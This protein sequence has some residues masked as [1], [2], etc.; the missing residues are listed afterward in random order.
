MPDPKHRRA[1]RAL[2]DRNARI[3]LVL[4]AGRR[5]G[6]SRLGQVAN[7]N[8]G[9]GGGQGAQHT[10][11]TQHR[12][13]ADP[14]EALQGAVRPFRRVGAPPRPGE[15]G[16]RDAGQPRALNGGDQFDGRLTDEAHGSK[17]VPLKQAHGDAF[18]HAVHLGPGAG[19]PCV[20]VFVQDHQ[21]VR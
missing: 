15:K 18:G 17:P 13:D 14:A 19:P 12:V 2:Q 8:G 6:A 4:K 16:H 7:G 11:M 21:V 20:G 9:V 3:I 5:R 10:A 1:R